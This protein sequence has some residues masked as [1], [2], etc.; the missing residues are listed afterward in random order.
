MSKRRSDY[1]EIRGTERDTYLLTWIGEQYAV[2]LDQLHELVNRL[3]GRQVSESNIKWLTDRWRRAGWVEKRKRLAY[4][5]QWVWLTKAGL[6]EIGLDYPY[7]EPALSRLPHIYQVNVVRMYIERELGEAAQW[8]SE[9]EA[10]AERREAK[11]QHQV[12]GEVLYQGTQIAVEVELTQKSAR[13][14]RS[15]LQELKRDYKAVWYFLADE[16]YEPVSKMIAGVAGHERTF[17]VYRLKK[18]V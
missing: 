1:G 4:Q 18:L 3:K 5:P 16:C 17:Q 14:L 6:D 12:D 10:N 7:R 11:K 8:V 13:R 9:R 2:R 15:V